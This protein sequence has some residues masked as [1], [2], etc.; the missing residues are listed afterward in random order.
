MK[1][2]YRIVMHYSNGWQSIHLWPGIKIV[3]TPE[4]THDREL[5]LKALADWRA[6]LPGEEFALVT[7]VPSISL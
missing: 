3:P 6:F 4:A 2:E 7:L 1:N 5:A